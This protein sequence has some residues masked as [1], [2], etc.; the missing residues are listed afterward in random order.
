VTVYGLWRQADQQ[1]NSSG[2]WLVD[3]AGRIMSGDSIEVMNAQRRN[4][5]AAGYTEVIVAEISLE[6][7]PIALP[8]RPG[9]V[10]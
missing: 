9:R 8:E 10:V 4:A 6:G 2:Y 5:L 1:G 3:G 7:E